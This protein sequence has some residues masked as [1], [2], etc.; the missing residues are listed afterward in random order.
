MTPT[1]P[2]TTRWAILAPGR[3]A[4]TFAGDLALTPGAELV[5]VGSRSEERAREFA[6]EF[7]V[8]AAYGTYEE[9]VA[10]PQVDVVYVASPHALHLEHARLA[11]EAGKHVLCEK[12]LTLSVAEAKQLI[13][14]A[15]EHDR[16]LM[17]AMWTACHPVVLA[18]RDRI[19][20]GDL[21]TPRQLHA[22]LGFV[23]P[24]NASPRML[25]PQ[26]GASALLD[27][28]IY[29]LTLAHLML[30]EAEQLTATA[31]LSDDGIDLDVAISGRYPGG[32]VATMTASLTSWSSRRAEIATDTGRLTLED[33][34]HP[35]V[36]T[37]TSFAGNVGDGTSGAAPELIRGA[38]PVLGHGFSHEIIEVGRCLAEGLRESPL[39]PH[40]QTLTILRQMDDVRRQVGVAFPTVD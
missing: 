35:D 6:G 33:F 32:A 28:G 18:V 37:W 21:G 3:I 4:R 24:P 22:E 26:L 39:V 38:V 20:S 36:A 9:L 1:T 7:G 19:R 13:A 25:Q 8:D 11:F 2:T 30:G 27:M 31:V 12:P 15:A 17:E 10:D 29:P 16:F 34:H 5:A 40:S 23:V 14:L